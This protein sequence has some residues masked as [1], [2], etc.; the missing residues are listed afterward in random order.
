MDPFQEAITGKENPGDLS[1]P[2]QAL[3]QFYRA[4]NSD[5][6]QLMSE[7]WSP[8]A[9]I[10]MDNPLGGIQRGCSERALAFA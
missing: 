9:D 7:N 10:A 4:F 2:F 1:S 5:D 8:S 6:M 3:I